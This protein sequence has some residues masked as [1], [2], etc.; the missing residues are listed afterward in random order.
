M[1]TFLEVP[2]FHNYMTIFRKNDYHNNNNIMDMPLS[3][4]I[5]LLINENNNF[6]V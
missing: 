3:F 5:T 6:K 1:D 4:L 2:Y